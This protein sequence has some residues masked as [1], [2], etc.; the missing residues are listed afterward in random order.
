[1]A[2]LGRPMVTS[3]S[4]LATPLPV[5]A[6]VRPILHTDLL[7]A[8]LARH[9]GVTAVL[10]KDLPAELEAAVYRLPLRVVARR[11]ATAGEEVRDGTVRVMSGGV[12][13]GAF[14]S[15]EELHQALLPSGGNR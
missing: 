11:P 6:A 2:V 4:R 14:T 9:H 3:F 1:M 10:G 5:Y 12:V 13:I 8:T 15:V 7:Q